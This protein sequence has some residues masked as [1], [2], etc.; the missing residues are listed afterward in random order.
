MKVDRTGKACRRGH[1]VSAWGTVWGWC[2]RCELTI[3]RETGM[4]ISYGQIFLDATEA[5]MYREAVS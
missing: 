3:H 5:A 2:P 4:V 1:A